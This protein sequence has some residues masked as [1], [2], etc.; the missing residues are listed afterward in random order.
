MELKVKSLGVS[1][2]HNPS[3]RIIGLKYLWC[4]FVLRAAEDRT[5]PAGLWTPERQNSLEVSSWLLLSCPRSTGEPLLPTWS[6]GLQG[7]GMLLSWRTVFFC[8][9]SC[10]SVVQVPTDQTQNE[11]GRVWQPNWDG[12]APR[13]IN[14]A[15][16]KTFP[17]KAFFSRPS[18]QKCRR[19]GG[20]DMSLGSLI[21]RAMWWGIRKIKLT[22]I[23]K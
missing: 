3:S 15:S 4:G 14:L 10:P 9:A 8:A 18:A 5:V 2:H 16:W 11:P 1:A 20:W 21:V 23:G 17:S 6:L 19:E 13:W 22:L 7:P 12:G